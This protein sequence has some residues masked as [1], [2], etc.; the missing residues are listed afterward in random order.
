MNSSDLASCAKV[1]S[2]NDTIRAVI[3]A[4]LHAEKMTR[5]DL[6]RAI[7][8][9]PQEVTRA[10]NGTRG[11]GT[12]PPLWAD[13]LAALGLTLT[14]V[15]VEHMGSGEALALPSAPTLDAEQLAQ[16]LEQLAQ[17]V[18]GGA[19]Q[20]STAPDSEPGSAAGDDS[21]P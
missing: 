8:R 1:L 10:L 19:A 16:H 17:V 2:V 6:A 4:R 18:R 13:M 11:G 20:P 7:N 5:S 14:A 12:V 15:P 21:T 3:N 9:T